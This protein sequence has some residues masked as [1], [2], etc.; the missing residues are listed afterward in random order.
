MASK[1]IFALV[2]AI[3]FAGALASD[4]MSQY[5]DLTAYGPWK[6]SKECKISLAD[7]IDSKACHFVSDDGITAELVL[8]NLGLTSI[9]DIQDML[10]C[11]DENDVLLSVDV[12]NNFVDCDRLLGTGTVVEASEEPGYNLTCDSFLQCGALVENDC[13]KYPSVCVFE[14][15]QCKSINAT[16]PNPKVIISLNSIVVS[17]P[18]E[19]AAKEESIKEIL[20]NY[21]GT[22]GVSSESVRITI[23]WVPSTSTTRRG[24]EDV[25]YVPVVTITFVVESEASLDAAQASAETLTKAAVE[26]TISD[27]EDFKNIG[28][29]LIKDNEKERPAK[30]VNKGKTEFGDG[31][32]AGVVVACVVLA[33]IIIVEIAFL[34]YSTRSNKRPVSNNDQENV[35]YVS[36]SEDDDSES[37]ESDSDSSDDS[38][39]SDEES[40]SYNGS[41]GDYSSSESE[42]KGEKAEKKAESESESESEEESESESESE[43]EEESESESESES[44][45]ESDSDSSSGSGSGSGSGSSESS[46]Q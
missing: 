25:T 33:I 4:C 32:I 43:S 46:S 31:A 23:E 7:A 28:V 27:D 1:F 21:L 18:E 15:Y 11:L 34:V 45:D 12:T 14:D 41:D 17:T 2:S 24:D 37:S 19:K 22:I 40:S 26:G 30:T 10:K 8:T 16:I 35:I 44:E 3:L 6:N 20:N 42:K 38:D 13:V 36:D 9:D 5:T 29:T 39:D